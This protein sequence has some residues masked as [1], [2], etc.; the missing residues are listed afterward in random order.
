[1]SP[2]QMLPGQMLLWRLA[3]FK[4]GP[5]NLPLKFGPNWATNSWAMYFF[6]WVAGGWVAGWLEKLELR[7]SQPQSIWIELNWD[8]VEVELGNNNHASP[9]RRRTS[10]FN[11]LH[12]LYNN[13]IS[14][15]AP[16]HRGCSFIMSHF[17][18]L[19]WIIHWQ[20]ASSFEVR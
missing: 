17:F 2:V 12:L 18:G 5:R 4:I 9:H 7:L 1:M 8:E 10:S 20:F 3:S 16:R 19:F 15:A 13:Q 6:G 14:Y 11:E